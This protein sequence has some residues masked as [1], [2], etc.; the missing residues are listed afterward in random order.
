MN[1]TYQSA[2]DPRKKYAPLAKWLKGLM[3]DISIQSDSNASIDDDTQFFANYHPHFYQQL[4]DFIMALLK[5]EADVV[6]KY[7]PLLYHLAGCTTCRQAYVELYDAMKAAVEPDGSHVSE[8]T[9]V[10]T[11]DTTP[12]NMLMLLCQLLIG[13]AEAVKRQAR[14]DHIDNDDLVR[15]LLQQ[16]LQVSKH[17]RQD[18]MR[19]KA[20]QNLVRVA[21]LFEEPVDQSPVIDSF[22]PHLVG[23]AGMRRV[24]R[25]AGTA[26][27]PTEQHVIYLASSRFKGTITISQEGDKLELL[28]QNLDKELYGHYLSIDIPLGSLIEPVRW[29]GG[30]PRNIRSIQPVDEH[31]TLRTPVGETDLRLSNSEDYN[32]LETTF[33]LLEVRKVE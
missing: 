31:G 8:V 16:V 13:Q 26:P 2:F 32:W 33:S 20:T 12:P 15:L 4:P 22:T 29:R 10:H 28:L 27:H 17:L 19:H 21:T 7:A 9:G 18:N 11:L 25:K 1:T 14:R 23:G 30:N 3:E 5:K 24:V 6:V